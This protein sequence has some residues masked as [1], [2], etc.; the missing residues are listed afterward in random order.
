MTRPPA[1]SIT[2]LTLVRLIPNMLT[3]G[4]VCAGITAIRFGVQGNYIVAVQ[5][6]LLAAV[7]DGIDGRVARYVGCDSQFGLELDSLADFLNF[8]V[9]PALIVYFWGM[10]D[11]GPF[12]WS[13]ALAFAICCILRLARF[14]VSA[15]DPSATAPASHFTGV[16][17]PAG[18]FLALAPLLLSFAFTD[19]PALPGIAV[20]L[21]M[22]FIGFLMVSRVPTPSFKSIRIARENRLLAIITVIVAVVALAAFEWITLLSACGAYLVAVLVS[23]VAELRRSEQSE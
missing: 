3:L 18:A 5:L 11:M 23:F 2:D 9:A 1:K 10:Q 6:I 17:A 7:L 13:V 19:R 21:Y 12:G 15:R 8:G 22:L 16:P 20:S 4:A 14:N